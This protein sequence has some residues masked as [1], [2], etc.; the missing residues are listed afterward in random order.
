MTDEEAAGSGWKVFL[1]PEADKVLKGLG[2]KD[3]ERIRSALLDLPE[4]DVVRMQG[5]DTTRFRLRVGG[6]R[7]IFT[8]DPSP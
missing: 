6:W 8:T 7:A 2:R 4:G 1:D 5:A 3:R